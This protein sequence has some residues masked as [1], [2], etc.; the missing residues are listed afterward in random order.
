MI[1]QIIHQTW[2]TPEVPEHFREF[3]R[4]F[5]DLHPAWEYR[6]WDDAANEQLIADHYPEFLPY[7]RTACPAI[8]KIDLVRLAYLHRHGGVYADLDCEPRR[9]LDPLTVGSRI[10][11]GRESGGIGRRIR[12]RD[13]IINALIISP[14]GHPVWPKIMRRMVAEYRA[15]HRFERHVVHVIRMGMAMFDE[16]LEEHAIAH[17]DV[18]ILGHEAFYP[19][20]PA[21]RRV[22]HR[23]H[24]GSTRNSYA[25]HH[26]ENSWFDSTAL[27]I[28]RIRD[29]LQRWSPWR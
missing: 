24:L 3:Q 9:P 26:Y 6:F 28:N 25:I 21:D 14:S 4:S 23:R 27:R 20:S 16:E 19:A 1:P 11:V 29:T 22:D 12:G 7:F 8:L 15:R 5:R 2:R 17:D 18:T 10:V 13:Y